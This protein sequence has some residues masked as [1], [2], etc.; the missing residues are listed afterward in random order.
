M[1]RLQ[2]KCRSAGAL[3]Y[4]LQCEQSEKIELYFFYRYTPQLFIIYQERFMYR[5]HIQGMSF[6]R[7][8]E[9]TF[10]E[11]SITPRML[12]VLCCIKGRTTLTQI[13]RRL[14]FSFEELCNEIYNLLHLNLIVFADNENLQE[15]VAV[16]AAENRYYTAPV[17]RVISAE[18]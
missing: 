5:S 12:Q 14:S 2:L 9:W 10:G 3:A 8:E 17:S 7:T 16:T 4:Y 18:M 1:R 6:M 11:I 13:E 15:G